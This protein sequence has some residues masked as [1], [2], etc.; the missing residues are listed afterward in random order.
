MLGYNLVYIGQEG[1]PISHPVDVGG[2]GSFRFLISSLGITGWKA[3]FEAPSL[4]D[5]LAQ[6]LVFV[7]FS[8]THDRTGGGGPEIPL[9]FSPFML[10]IVGC[11]KVLIASRDKAHSRRAAPSL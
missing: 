9:Q 8:S 3:T 4:R 7:A 5:N 10:H 11:H 6:F 2:V 1:T